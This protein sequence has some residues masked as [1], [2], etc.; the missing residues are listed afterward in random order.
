MR[1]SNDYEVS[2]TGNAWGKL[3]VY[4]YNLTATVVGGEGWEVRHK[5]DSTVRND[6]GKINSSP[7][8]LMSPIVTLPKNIQYT[9]PIPFTDD[10]N[11]VI[12][13]R[14]AS[15]MKGECDGNILCV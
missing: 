8:T 15:W 12:R 4:G 5:L 6:T 11:D 2:Y 9:I 3:V 1:K 10:D 13:C 7:T 14:W